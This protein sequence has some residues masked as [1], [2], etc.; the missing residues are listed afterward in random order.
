MVQIKT[1]IRQIADDYAGGNGNITGAVVEV[2]NG[3]YK[4]VWVTQ[5]SRPFES[6]AVYKRV[7]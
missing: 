4:E 2:M 7:L 3:E 6:K 1:D 5:S